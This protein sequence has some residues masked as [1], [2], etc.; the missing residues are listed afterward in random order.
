[1]KKTLI[2][3]IIPLF[4]LSVNVQAESISLS[5]NASDISEAHFTITI[6]STESTANYKTYYWSVDSKFIVD[7]NVV[8]DK[9]LESGTS[10]VNPGQ[11][12][13]A[14]ADITI[15][16]G[17]SLAIESDA[18]N[19]GSGTN[20]TL[21]N[22][23]LRGSA[24]FN[25]KLGGNITVFRDSSTLDMDSNSN[26][27]A[28][29]VRL[30]QNVT[31]NID[32]NFKV[33]VI[34][35]RANKKGTLSPTINMNKAF[36]IMKANG[37]FGTG[38]SMMHNNSDGRLNVNVNASQVLGDLA[39]MKGSDTLTITFD[40]DAFLAFNTITTESSSDR[41]LSN[42]VD[43]V[44][45]DFTN[46]SLFFKTDV[47][48]ML[49]SYGANGQQ[50]FAVAD[51]HLILSGTDTNGKALSGFRLSELT[52]IDAN[53]TTV[54][55]YWLMADSIIPEP[56]EWAAIFGALALGLAIYRRRK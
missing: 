14:T 51:G 42:D 49:V 10:K 6:P 25:D 34:D 38:L 17:S 26:F 39:V 5:G 22:L 56:A 15:N 52:S 27:K 13:S 46:N 45:T 7:S 16:D 40:N 36:S 37:S 1:M 24:L 2:S 29:R 30:Q 3:S 9:V 33:D 43:L 23:T 44:L 50:A 31:L 35:T 28:A 4:A 20:I 55:G 8:L 48:S 11:T 32:G 54:N 12:F 21:S 19:S 41:K 47:S 18:T 53:G